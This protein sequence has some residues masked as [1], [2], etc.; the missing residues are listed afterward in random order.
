M[1]VM[2]GGTVKSNKAL[3]AATWA[4]GMELED[5]EGTALHQRT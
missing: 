2:Y 1:Y 4:L 5:V 3:L